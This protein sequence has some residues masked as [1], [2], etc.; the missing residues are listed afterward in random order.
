VK[1]I[2]TSLAE[3]MAELRRRHKFGRGKPHRK[4]VDFSRRNIIDYN[5]N[6]ELK[7]KNHLLQTPFQT[8]YILADLSVKHRYVF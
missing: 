2:V 6:M 5:P 4:D 3:G 7:K 1:P 8:Y